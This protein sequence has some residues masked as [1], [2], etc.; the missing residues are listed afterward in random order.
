MRLYIGVDGGAS[1]TEAIILNEKGV[2]I[3]KVRID[4][5]TNLKIFKDW[6]KT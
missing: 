5:G 1:K 2:T 4:K 6:P 3:N